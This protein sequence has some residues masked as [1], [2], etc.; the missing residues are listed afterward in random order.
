M[1]MTGPGRAPT[2]RRSLVERETFQV[3]VQPQQL[4]DPRIVFDDERPAGRARI[5][6]DDILAWPDISPLC[7]PRRE[8]CLVAPTA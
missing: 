1:V 5:G 2:G 4:A 7:G 3:E 6:H 8:S